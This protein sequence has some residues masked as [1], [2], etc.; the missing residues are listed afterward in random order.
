MQPGSGRRVVDLSTET[1]MKTFDDDIRKFIEQTK[2]KAAA[3]QKKLALE[4]AE[5]LVYYAPIWTGA[6]VKSMRCGIDM[7]DTSHEPY[8]SGLP[9]YPPRVDEMTAEAIRMSMLAKLKAE[10]ESA[11]VGSKIYLSNSI[12][13]AD[14]IEYTGWIGQE[15]YQVF[16]TT[17]LDLEFM[18]P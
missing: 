17:I 1:A 14:Q 2:E 12:P 3:E 15:A 7:P 9:P 4:A 18:Q 8:Y 10:I 13:Y 16:T 11:P 6:Y 5:R